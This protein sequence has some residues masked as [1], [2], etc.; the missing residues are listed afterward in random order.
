MTSSSILMTGASTFIGFAC[1]VQALKNGYRVR[2]AVRS[3]SKM[4]LILSN[5]LIRSLSPGGRLSFI[6]IADFT[7][8]TS[9]NPAVVDMDSVIHLATPK[10]RDRFRNDSEFIHTAVGMATAI[11]HAACRSTSIKRVVITSSMVALRSGDR[12]ATIPVSGDS[13][14]PNLDE[15]Y[16]NAALKYVASK[17]ATLNA[18]DDFI[19]TENPPFFVVN[20]VPGWTIGPHALA[21]SGEALLQTSNMMVLLPL[22]GKTL[23]YSGRPISPIVHL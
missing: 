13:H 17:V 10:P 22:L 19:R 18:I 9:W 23:P 2:C 12:G 16:A 20:L 8:T 15:P 1:L 5:E 4:D 21:T 6:E 14:I 11:L 3:Q 7:N